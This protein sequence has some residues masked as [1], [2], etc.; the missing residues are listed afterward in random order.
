MNITFHDL[1]IP[2]AL[3]RRLSYS[4]GTRT[5]YIDPHPKSIRGIMKI[6]KNKEENFTEQMGILV[7]KQ[8]ESFDIQ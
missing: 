2:M 7:V 8:V 5:L 6:L 1:S 3:V 4:A